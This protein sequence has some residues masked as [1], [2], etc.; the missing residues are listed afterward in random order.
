MGPGNKDGGEGKREKIRGAIS[1]FDDCMAKA[2]DQVT[3]GGRTW[4]R[5]N[6]MVAVCVG[7][8]KGGI[9]SR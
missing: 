1:A 9:D 8:K 7:E 6:T 3:R 4:K 2:V 5:R